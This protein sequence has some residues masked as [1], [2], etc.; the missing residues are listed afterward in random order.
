[1]AKELKA[2]RLSAKTIANLKRL[3]KQWKVSQ[4][5]IIAVLAK[6]AVESKSDAIED[7]LDEQI[8]TILEARN[9]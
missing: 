5:D 4:A 1:M 3:S 7:A 8:E 2:F 9:L 6:I